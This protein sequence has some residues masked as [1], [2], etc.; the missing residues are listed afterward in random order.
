MSTLQ[1]WFEATRPKTLP[2]AVAPVVLGTA[3]AH[4]DE[5]LHLLP[6]AF[7]LAFALLVQIGTNFAIDYLDGI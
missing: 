5:Q 6:A 1:L 4:S 3:M 2:A 7:C